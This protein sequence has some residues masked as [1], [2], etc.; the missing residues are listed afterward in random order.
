MSKE[1]T[2]APDHPEPRA[3][4]ICRRRGAAALIPPRRG[5]AGWSHHLRSQALTSSPFEVPERAW[6]TDL[7]A[8]LLWA[9]PAFSFMLV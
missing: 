2:K 4:V 3:L 6:S 1:Q 8:L 9:T 5:A 7:A